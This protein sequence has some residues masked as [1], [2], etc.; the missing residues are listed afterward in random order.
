MKIIVDA[1]AC[2]KVI[3]EILYRA[4]KR[5]K[6][7]LLLVANQSLTTPPSPFIKSLTVGQGFDV[8]DD[9]IVE[10][11]VAGDLIITADIPLA[12]RVIQK[13]A[14]ALNPRGL[15]YSKENIKQRLATRD[16]MQQ[17]RDSGTISGGPAA[18]NNRDKQA[19]ANEL[20]KLL[21]HLK[22]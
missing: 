15:L 11:S 13:D 14:V 2:P 20:D 10:I 21:T 7:S 4:A 12:D 17:L 18:I 1:D 16:L 19:F 22:R 8:A 5:E 6:I 3:K 9:K